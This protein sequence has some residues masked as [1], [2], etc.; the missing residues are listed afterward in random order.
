MSN[1]KH[2][3]KDD[4]IS[5]YYHEWGSKVDSLL[6]TWYNVNPKTGQIAR[7]TITSVGDI[8]ELHA[9]GQLESKEL[10][11]GSAVCELFSSNVG[12]PEIE[13]FKCDFDFDFM[14]TSIAGN[15]K[16]GVM[17]I[18]SYNTFKDQSERNNYF[19]R[20]FFCKK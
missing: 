4:I 16:Y 3:K 2:T 6:G 7:L 19:S 10:D 17:V 15:M 9:I 12:S 20:E 8:L 18:Q 14:Q 13:G 1:L 11:W 5:E